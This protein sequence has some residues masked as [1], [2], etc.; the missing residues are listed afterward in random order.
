MESLPR[1]HQASLQVAVPY[2]EDLRVSIA[3][4]PPS[5]KA[6]VKHVKHQRTQAFDIAIW[7]KRMEDVRHQPW[8]L[9]YTFFEDVSPRYE[10]TPTQLAL[11]PV[12]ISPSDDSGVFSRL[13]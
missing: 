4:L 9:R 1:N 8:G 12:W 3:S 6:C 13:R 7:W 2:F 11:P 10:R 5:V